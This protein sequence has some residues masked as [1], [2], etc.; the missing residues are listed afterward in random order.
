[1]AVKTPSWFKLL[2]S[3]YSCV[4]F[5]FEKS[6]KDFTLYSP[7]L[8][9]LWFSYLQIPIKESCMYVSCHSF[10][11]TPH[12]SLKFKQT[13]L[14]LQTK[15]IYKQTRQNEGIL[16]WYSQKKNINNVQAMLLQSERVSEI[17]F[18]AIWRLKFHKFSLWHPP[19]QYL[20]EKVS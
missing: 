3:I 12:K 7:I 2:N 10:F 5:C 16:K 13:L 19:W 9:T 8:F 20:K 11:K 4:F 1:M 15:K 14:P 17:H 6:L 18:P